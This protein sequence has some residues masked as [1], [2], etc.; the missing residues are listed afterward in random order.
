VSRPFRA[1]SRIAPHGA[2]DRLTRTGIRPVHGTVE[3][4]GAEPPGAFPC[5]PAPLH[6]GPLKGRGGVERANARRPVGLSTMAR[7]TPTSAPR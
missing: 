4:Y 1:A 3:V 7:S 6:P 2:V 5:C